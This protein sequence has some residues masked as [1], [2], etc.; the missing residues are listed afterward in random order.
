MQAE[1][2]QA[3]LQTAGEIINEDMDE[4][5]SSV[6]D[7][8]Q[9]YRWQIFFSRGNPFKCFIFIFKTALKFMLEQ[10][11][12]AWSVNCQWSVW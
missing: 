9:L 2:K 7:Y 10:N 1:L 8:M 12:F 4:L 11:F 5:C 3:A 6:I